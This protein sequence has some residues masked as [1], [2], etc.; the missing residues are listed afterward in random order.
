MLPD[1]ESASS[2]CKT[3]GINIIP[4]RIVA[5]HIPIRAVPRRILAHKP[6]N[7]RV[8]HPRLRVPQPQSL[9]VAV[10]RVA[11][12]RFRAGKVRVRVRL[13]QRAAPNVVARVGDDLA[14]RVHGAEGRAE[15]GAAVPDLVNALRRNVRRGVLSYLTSFVYRA[16]QIVLSQNA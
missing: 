7:L 5:V 3:I 2:P 10:R 11:K 16:A 12:Q 15:I 14:A 8:I 4:R 9:I 13:G 6:P 1:H